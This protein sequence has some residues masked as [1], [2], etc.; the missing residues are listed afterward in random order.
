LQGKLNS[1]KTNIDNQPVAPVMAQAGGTIAVG[2]GP[3]LG[4]PTIVGEIALGLSVI[5]VIGIGLSRLPYQNL[6]QDI[7]AISATYQNYIQQLQLQTVFSQGSSHPHAAQIIQL[8]NEKVT[9]TTNIGKLQEAIDNIKS[10]MA[11]G[12]VE[13]GLDEIGFDEQ[14][15]ERIQNA[16]DNIR[17]LRDRN[18]EITKLIDDLL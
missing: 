13:S 1:F 9:N 16:I 10:Q 7:N 4:E 18:A 8:Q 5:G 17:Q 2:I 3:A 12:A 14:L 15:Q 11:A 6:A